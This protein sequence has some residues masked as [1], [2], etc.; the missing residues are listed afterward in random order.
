[1]PD[2]IMLWDSR[3]TSMLPKKQTHAI[4]HNLAETQ[5]VVIGQGE[6][7]RW[8]VKPYSVAVFFRPHTSASWDMVPQN[9]W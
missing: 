3:R 6:T 9:H 1:M 7:D 2:H 5:G 8:Y 4:V